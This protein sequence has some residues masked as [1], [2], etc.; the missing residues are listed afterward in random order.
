[1]N[2]LT[3]QDIKDATWKKNWMDLSNERPLGCLLERPKMEKG[4]GSS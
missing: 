3:C 2:I 1:M 4:Y